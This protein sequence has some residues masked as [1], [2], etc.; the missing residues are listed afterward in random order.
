MTRTNYLLWQLAQEA[1][2]LI[3][4]LDARN[5]EAIH[6]E[7]NDL[8][9]VIQ[10][11]Q[12]EGIIEYFQMQTVRPSPIPALT[13]LIQRTSK[14]AQFG[15]AESQ[16]GHPNNR[17]RLTSACQIIHSDLMSHADSQLLANKTAKVEQ[18]YKYSLSCETSWH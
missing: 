6:F 17:T 13:T 7:A 9:A 16:P 2:E 15:L 18:F 1:A 4:A 5:Q 8:L 10:M 12:V 11:C 3:E 14:A